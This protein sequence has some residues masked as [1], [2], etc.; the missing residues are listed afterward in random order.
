[1]LSVVR[2][3]KESLDC[4]HEELMIDCATKCEYDKTALCDY[5]AYIEW[6]VNEANKRGL[7]AIE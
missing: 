4:I 5:Q 1:M 2:R 3:I 6:Q 7:K